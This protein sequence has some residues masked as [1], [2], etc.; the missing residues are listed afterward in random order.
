[1]QYTLYHNYTAE[2]I[3]CTINSRVARKMN[4]VRQNTILK[5]HPSNIMHD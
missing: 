4:D 2:I 3:E 1:M 5:N